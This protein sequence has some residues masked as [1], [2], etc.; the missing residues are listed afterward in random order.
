[1]FF[2]LS[3]SSSSVVQR[4]FVLFFCSKNFQ[5]WYS[6]FESDS[7][8]YSLCARLR[9]SALI[10]FKGGCAPQLVSENIRNRSQEVIKLSS[11]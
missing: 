2:F 3:V 10:N 4:F 6:P 5:V 1:M 7:F 9:K 8:K 11:A